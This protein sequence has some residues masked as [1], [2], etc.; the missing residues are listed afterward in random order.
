MTFTEYSATF[1]I[2]M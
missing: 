2:Q 1:Y